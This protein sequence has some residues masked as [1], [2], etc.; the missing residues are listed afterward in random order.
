MMDLTESS[1]KMLQEVESMLNQ[2]KARLAVVNEREQLYK[3]PIPGAADLAQ[4]AQ[5]CHELESKVQ[6][7]I[8]QLPGPT[9]QEQEQWAK[10]SANW[11]PDGLSE[12]PNL[13]WS[14]PGLIKPRER[15]EQK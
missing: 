15:K 5:D 14:I 6:E 12:N 2:C 7:C 10:S 11:C 8:K 4:G 1:R 13:I 9:Q 3:D